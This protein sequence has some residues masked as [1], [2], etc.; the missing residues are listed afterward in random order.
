MQSNIQKHIF[1]IANIS[2]PESLSHEQA[3]LR[4]AMFLDPYTLAIRF[5][6]DGLRYAVVR[7]LLFH[8]T[9]IV[10]T[11]DDHLTYTTRWCYATRAQA[12]DA[13]FDPTWDGVRDPGFGWNRHPDTDRV[14]EPDPALMNYLQRC[15]ALEIETP[16]AAIAHDLDSRLAMIL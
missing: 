14:V 10:G 3:E 13:V 8:Y 11:V 5:F 6:R 7:R 16:W 4:T 15:Q 1:Q 9:A 2:E 12:M